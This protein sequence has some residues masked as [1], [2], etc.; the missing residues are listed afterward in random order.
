MTL[1]DFNEFVRPWVDGA[2]YTILIVQFVALVIYA[3]RHWSRR[4]SS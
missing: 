3:Y 4:K 2:V 1:H